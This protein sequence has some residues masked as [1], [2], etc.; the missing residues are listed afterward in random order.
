M[1]DR[2]VFP[3]EQGARKAPARE[4][5]ALDAKST[6]TQIQETNRDTTSGS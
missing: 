4:P 2:S 3:G 1:A 6:I 5:I